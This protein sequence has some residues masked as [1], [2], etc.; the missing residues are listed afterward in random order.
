MHMLL[1][2]KDPT[3]WA[4]EI[5]INCMIDWRTTAFILNSTMISAY[6]QDRVWTTAKAMAS[7]S[8]DPNGCCRFQYYYDSIQG[9]TLHSLLRLPAGKTF[10]ALC[11]TTLSETQGIFKDYYFL[12]VDEK[13]MI[14]LKNLHRIDQQLRQIFPTRQDGL[15]GDWIFLY[16]MSLPHSIKSNASGVPSRQEKSLRVIHRHGGSNSSNA[17]TERTWRVSSIQALSELREVAVT[18]EEL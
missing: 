14:G 8:S 9:R 17:A 7:P 16:S 3:C 5:W 11:A 12:I 2:L 18:E 1:E 13:L 4:R 10:A 15:F 6:L